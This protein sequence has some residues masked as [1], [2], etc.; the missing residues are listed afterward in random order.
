MLAWLLAALVGGSI[1]YCFLVVI[2]ARA[3][4]T[5]PRA[6]IGGLTPISILKPLAG[7]EDGLETNLRSFFTQ[8]YPQFEILFAVRRADDAACATVERLMREY[9]HVPA[10][11]MITG[12]PP[13]PNAK[14]YSLSRMMAEARHELLAMCDSDIR[15]GKDFLRTVA[16]EFQHGSMDLTTC[17]YRA[18]PGAGFW[19]TIEAI[20]MNTEFLAG[21]LVARWIEGMKFAVGPT[22]VARKRVIEGIGGWDRVKD[23]LAEDFVLGR[24]AA[25]AGFAV[26]L[27]SYVVEHHIG[28]SRFADNM[29]HRLR[30]GRSTRRSRPAGYAGQL[31][32]YTLPLAALLLIVAPQWWPLATCALVARGAAAW[33][34]A[35]S[36]L[37]DPLCARLWC[38][39]PFEDLVSFFLW[40]GGF[41]G[42]TIVWR[43]RNYHLKPDGTFELT[44]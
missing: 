4:R 14:V 24:F 21:I 11:L 12:E 13:Y 1:V 44:A 37:R 3:Y 20:G 40:I 6:S 42:N 31:F 10:R 7:A 5:E 2:A 22:I 8:D 23:Y 25:E 34:T 17:P 38:L 28:S 26:G 9:R 43:G 16:A 33:A 15:V 29:R 19:S 36:I 39:I 30:W 27:S 32:T 35:G 41:A 18:V